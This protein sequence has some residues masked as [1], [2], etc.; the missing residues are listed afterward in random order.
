MG[1]QTSLFSPQQTAAATSQYASDAFAPDLNFLLKQFA[2]PGMSLDAGSIGS[3]L[4]QISAGQGNAAQIQAMQPLLDMLTNQ[5]FLG[6]SQA[7]QG[8]E[9]LNLANIGY[10][11]QNYQANARQSQLMP[12]LQMLLGQI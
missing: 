11:T 2:R 9:A 3:A 7:Q 5:Q 10:S 4:P 1:V 6:E 8:N 12:L